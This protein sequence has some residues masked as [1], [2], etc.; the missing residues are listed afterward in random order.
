MVKKELHCSVEVAY[1]IFVTMIFENHRQELN[2][3]LDEVEVNRDH[4]QQ[5]LSEQTA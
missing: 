3:Q 2:E 1:E 4:L 5:S